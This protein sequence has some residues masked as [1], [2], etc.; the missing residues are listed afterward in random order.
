MMRAIR[1]R[2]SEKGAARA[3]HARRVADRPHRIGYRR[4][5]G[6]CRLTFVFLSALLIC[7]CSGPKGKVG[8]VRQSESES[9]YKLVI[10]RAQEI[11]GC[12][13]N[14]SRDLIVEPIDSNNLY[15]IKKGLRHFTGEIEKAIGDY[16][17]PDSSA[18]QQALE[19][20]NA[21]SKGNMKYRLSKIGYNELMNNAVL[22]EL[23][24]INPELGHGTFILLK[25]DG[26]EWSIDTE[27]MK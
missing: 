20:A 19:R 27:I 13:I 1:S 25:K 24:N 11:E 10:D 6:L 23:D 2:G 3:V 5:G 8:G 12:K 26:S 18:S 21:T 16:N 14:A 22:Y 9:I 15:L 4:L 17:G 7:S